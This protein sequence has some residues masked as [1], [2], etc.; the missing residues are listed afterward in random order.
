MTLSLEL[1][2]AIWLG[3]LTMVRGKL[4][5]LALHS[6]FSELANSY[7]FSFVSGMTRE[8]KR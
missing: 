4:N 8:S 6:F 5:S 2:S 3:N 7:S 1:L